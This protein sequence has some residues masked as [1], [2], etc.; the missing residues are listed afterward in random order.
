LGQLR[1]Q[2]SNLRP[3]VYETRELANCSTPHL[4]RL[5][6]LSSHKGL[7]FGSSGY[8]SSRG[9]FALASQFAAFFCGKARPDGSFAL[10]VAHNRQALT[11]APGRS[12]TRPHP[13]ESRSRSHERLRCKVPLLSRL[14][15][16]PACN[17]GCLGLASACA[18]FPCASLRSTGYQ[19]AA[20]I[21]HAGQM[22][23]R[24]SVETIAPESNR[25][26]AVPTLSQAD[27]QRGLPRSFEG[28]Q[29]LSGIHG[30]VSSPVTLR[31][32]PP[33]MDIA[34]SLRLSR[35]VFAGFTRI[36]VRERVTLPLSG[37]VLAN[38]YST[39]SGITPVSPFETTA[40]ELH[41][42]TRLPVPPSSLGISRLR[43]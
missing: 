2:D 36:G 22:G 17:R 6:G 41:R 43:A 19:A 39:N 42:A 14:V 27:R 8:R 11:S 10:G 1:G 26:A 4:G 21:P 38:R 9:R 29:A 18:N 16:L 20:P 24:G 7:S 15:T 34:P 33:A 12:R 25:V 31:V 28:H 40:P 13:A 37:W 23:L 30:R 32:R 5:S 35:L 3:R